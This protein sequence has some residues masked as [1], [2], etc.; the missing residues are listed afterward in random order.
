MIRDSLFQIPFVETLWCTHSLLQYTLFSTMSFKMK[1]KEK[2]WTVLMPHWD[3][4]H[5][6]CDH[7]VT[8]TVRTLDTVWTSTLSHCK[9]FLNLF[10]ATIQC[11]H[12]VWAYCITLWHT[13]DTKENTVWTVFT[14]SHCDLFHIPFLWLKCYA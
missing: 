2:M 12:N 6:S 10:A 11:A 4:V 14:L 3:H 9:C 1:K 5:I 8:H 13:L 7:T